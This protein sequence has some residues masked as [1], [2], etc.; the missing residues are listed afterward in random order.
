MPAYGA[1]PLLSAGPS[2][3]GKTSLL[4]IL[5]A[6]AQKAMRVEGVCTFNG[7]PLTKRLKRRMGYV[8]QVGTRPP[9]WLAPRTRPPRRPPGRGGKWTPLGSC[10]AAVH[11]CAA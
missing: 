6:R 2:G 9:G 8:L 1:R 4:S 11:W 3:S 10:S 5:G 7:Q